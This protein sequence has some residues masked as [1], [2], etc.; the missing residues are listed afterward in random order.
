MAATAAADEHRAA[1][2]REYEEAQRQQEEDTDREI[3]NIKAKCANQ[4]LC[5]FF[6][7][8]CSAAT[9]AIT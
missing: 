3:E 5:D 1:I 6:P 8:L 2:E 9:L 4:H 7:I